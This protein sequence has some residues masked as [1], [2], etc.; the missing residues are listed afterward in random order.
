MPRVLIDTNILL[1]AVDISHPQHK[2][3][4]DSQISLRLA[5]EELCLFDQN[6][7]EFRAVATRPGSS[8]GMGM[9]QQQS[10]SELKSLKSIYVHLSDTPSV[11]VE[12]EQL[13]AKYVSEGKQNHDARIVAAMIVHSVPR[14]LTFNDSDFR[15]YAEID[16][17]SPDVVLSQ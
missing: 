3:A 16:V 13:V 11:F 14:I 12:W 8:N 1:R 2:L 7:V 4:V 10:N 5:G 9:T 6:L 15:R 17:I